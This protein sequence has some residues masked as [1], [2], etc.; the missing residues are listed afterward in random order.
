MAALQR[1]L[2]DRK[3]WI[4]QDDYAL[5]YSLARVTPGTNVLAFCAAT[6]A[7]ILGVWGAIAAVLA[8]T[9]PSAVLAVLL[10]QGY[11]TWRTNPTVM[12]AVTGTIA[13]VAGMMWSSV[14][15][16]VRPHFGG[17]R[18]TIRTILFA[19]GSFI[20]AWKFGVTPIPIILVATLAGF[21]WKEREAA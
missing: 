1:E 10:T 16:L 2:I 12:A 13:A 20:A 14:W 9:F 5:A 8:V 3:G 17:L 15:L 7:R 6:G 11:E 4:N 21:L 19:G 18:R